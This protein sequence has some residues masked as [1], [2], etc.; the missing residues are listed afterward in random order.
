MVNARRAHNGLKLDSGRPD[1]ATVTTHALRLA[2]LGRWRPFVRMTRI[3]VCRVA[4][5]RLGRVLD[6]AVR[7][8]VEVLAPRGL[9]EQAV[10]AALILGWLKVFDPLPNDRGGIRPGVRV[11][12]AVG[13]Y[14]PRNRRLILN[15]VRSLR[16]ISKACGHFRLNHTALVPTSN[17]LRDLPTLPTF[18]VSHP[19]LRSG[20]PLVLYAAHSSSP[21][22]SP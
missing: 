8:R 22:P 4:V 12:I 6:S 16:D 13:M 9:K 14:P 2:R 7:H 18:I 10:A 11:V 5:F 15:V 1:G 20:L 21:G 19:T 3:A 17:L